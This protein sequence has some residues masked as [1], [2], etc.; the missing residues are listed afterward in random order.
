MHPLAVFAIALGGAIIIYGGYEAINT[1]YEWHNDRKEQREYEEYVR[2]HSEKH[3]GLVPVTIFE[4]ESDN[5]SDDDEPLAFWKKKRES[6][7]HQSELRRRKMFPQEDKQIEMSINEKEE[8]VAP[9]VNTDILSTELNPFVDENSPKAKADFEEQQRL[10]SLR[11]NSITGIPFD[12]DN[13]VEE[14]PFAD[15]LFM[16]ET[17]S[18]KEILASEIK[19]YVNSFVQR[20]S[21]PELNTT[22]EE[23]ENKDTILSDSESFY[24]FSN[25]NFA[26][27][28]KDDQYQSA[29]NKSDNDS[30][31][32]LDD[33]QL[34]DHSMKKSESTESFQSIQHPHP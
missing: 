4:N 33:A 8:M 14:N 17:D 1:L 29:V 27:V 22:A 3:G 15:G 19:D 34:S 20:P 24:Q 26:I 16:G 13:S 6:P 5:D 23:A 28:G 25:N 18:P 32:D 31:S 7:N 2:M 10:L 12:D 11:G 21:T 30:W 9:T